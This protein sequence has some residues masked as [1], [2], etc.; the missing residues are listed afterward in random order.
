MGGFERHG[1]IL[2]VQLSK[3]A[4]LTYNKACLAFPK[5]HPSGIIVWLLP[6]LFD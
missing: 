4:G 2:K 3:K 6:Y 5:L 1:V